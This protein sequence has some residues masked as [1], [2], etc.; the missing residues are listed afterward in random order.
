MKVAVNT[1]KLL[2]NV[3]LP[4]EIATVH[5]NAVVIDL[6]TGSTRIGFS[7]DDAPRLEA[8]TVIS[9]AKDGTV[10]CFSKAYK[11]RETTPVTRVMD[12]GLVKDWAGLEHIM[13]H[14]YELLNLSNDP[15]APVLI[16]EAA[17]VPK[18]QREQMVQLLFEKVKINSLYFSTAPVL[19]LYSSGRTTGM[20]VEM[21]HG[22][23]HTVPIFEGFGLFHSILELDYGG[24]D[25]TEMVMQMMRSNGA[26]VSPAHQYEVAQYLKETHCVTQPDKGSYTIA[27]AEANKHDTV[28][29]ELPDGTTVTLNNDRY[30]PTEALFDPSIIGREGLRGGG[31]QILAAESVKKCDADIAPLMLGN[32][33]LSGGTSLFRNMAE[34]LHREVQEQCPLEKVRVHAGTERRHAPWVGGSI[35][36][37]LPTV[38]DMWVTRAEYD[39]MGPDVRRSIAHRNC[40]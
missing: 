5:D 29:H 20:V 11:A 35:F 1:A 38:Q 16:S 34:R 10:E 22:T 37:S 9:T 12:R 6:G 15:N 28:S 36:A 27:V 4:D 25:L 31:I 39:E 2:R 26:N 21:G 17:L 14:V 24:T 30:K 7:G 3:P 13:M 8:P 23:C 18:E 32:I 40:F 19:S 33:V